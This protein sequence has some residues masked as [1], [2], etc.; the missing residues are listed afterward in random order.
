M[1]LV[2][3][4]GFEA[5]AGPTHEPVLGF[6]VLPQNPSA[7]TLVAGPNGYLWGTAD[8][9][10]AYG[11][12]A[13]YKAKMDG[14]DWQTVASFSNNGATNKGRLPAA[15]LVSDGAG[16]FWGT[17][18]Q[19]GSNNLGTVFKVNA[20][21]GAITTYVEFTGTA[22]PNKGSKPYGG[23]VSDG[24]G[25]FWGTTREGGSGNLLGMG[26]IFK[27]DANTG[28]L[29][30]VVEFTDSGTTKGMNPQA[31]LFSDGAGN[32]WGTTFYGGAS[33][34]GTVFKINT[35]SG[36][37]STVV[38]FANNSTTKGG[39]PAAPLMSDGAGS[40][41]GTTTVGGATNNGT[42]FKVNQTSSALTTVIEFTNNGATNKGKAPTAGLVRDTTG[43]LWGTTSA[44]GTGGY[45]TVF[46][47]D[48]SSN[49]LT[50]V[51]LFNY[52]AG[53]NKG[54]YPSAGLFSDGA[55]SIFGTTPSGAAQLLGSVFRINAGTSA[56]TTLVEFNYGAVS[57]R[58][59]APYGALVAD[60]AGTLWSTTSTGGANGAGTIF[61][62]DPVSGAQAVVVDFTGNTGG[63]LGSSP[64]PGLVSDGA[65]SFW[66]TTQYGGTAGY[67]TIFKVNATTGLLTTVVSFTNLGGGF[68]GA[69]PAA[70]L[71]GDGAGNFWGTTTNGGAG[72]YGTVFKVN[73]ISGLFTTVQEFTSN[74]A[75]NKGANPYA[76]LTNDSAGSFWGVTYSGGTPNLG[77][78]YKVNIASGLLT[79]V[80]EFNGTAA[81]NDGANPWGALVNDGAG[82]MWGTTQMGGT[83]GFGTLF[84]VNIT[85]SLLTTI[86]EFTGNGGAYPGAS[87]SAALVSD[88]AGAYWGTTLYGGATNVGTVFKLVTATS[89]LT[90]VAQFTGTGAQ[91]FSGA[92][93]GYGPL[94]KAAD[95]NFYGTTQNGGPGGGGTVFRLRFGPTPLTQA[96]TSVT[97]T[98]ATLNGTVN[99]NG[100]G[101]TT[102]SFDYGI[103][104]T[105]TGAVQTTTTTILNGTAASPASIPVSGLA[106][107]TTYYYRVRATNAGNATAQLGAA[108][109]FT[110][111]V[112]NPPTGGSFSVTPGTGVQQGDT[113]HLSAPGWTD[114]QTPLSYQFFRDAASL[115]AAGSATTL[116]VVAPA[117][118]TYLFR[119]RVADALGSYTEATQSVSVIASITSWRQLHF[120]T[121]ANSGIAA[122]DADPNGNGIGNLLEYTLNGNPTATTGATSILPTFSVNAGHR[123]QYTFTRYLDRT[124]LTLSVAAAD[125]LSGPWSDLA[126]STAAAPF[127]AVAPGAVAA[128]T[129]SG[130][131]RQVTVTD[132]VLVTDPG[133]S[134]RFLRLNVT[135]SV[136]PSVAS[137]R[138]EHFGSKASSRIAAN[139][140]D[141]NGNGIGNLLEYAL[142]GDPM[143]AAGATGILPTSTIGI[144]GKL[145]YSFTR[146]LDRTDLA[147]SVAVANSPNGPWTDLA[148][149]TA[150]ATFVVIAPGAAVAE[151]GVG[152]ARQVTI[153]DSV[154]VTDPD[155][156]HRFLR[157]KVTQ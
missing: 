72:G 46:K 6:A 8:Q 118:G 27:I 92:N 89:A 22:A 3:I 83:T 156:P 37:L 74:G 44:G 114:P 13:I 120:G 54:A 122:D 141:P 140:A 61:K 67:G 102:A 29:T 66:G 125:S 98:T 149:S 119:V 57:N 101:D 50:T 17:T 73:A 33:F 11:F 88:G 77:T 108:S 63:N 144:D 132:S 121:T 100:D 115:G 128:E 15:G 86:F 43:M 65:G 45:G 87:P 151:S 21:T 138:V 82:S 84:K 127:V 81:P 103:T 32:L 41:W 18:Q 40:F 112:N 68:K 111:L 78:I 10:G 133:H 71:V 123:I 26:T 91:A 7:G 35:T 95:G 75:T 145:Q 130:N 28:V 93:P 154:L 69:Y 157:L 134:H 39:Q 110:T 62:V 42:V 105:F 19:G 153:T 135:H 5:V 109:S 56:F 60:A 146:Y 131:T 47:I 76:A 117:P 139:D 31:G 94:Y 106:P 96:A 9:G 30:T 152:G 85:S 2:V 99:P 34:W 20:A 97:F 49:L 58:G 142:S 38:E 51:T 24:A 155:Y 1:F 148:T 64:Y 36:V 55:G 79:T 12:G 150:A 48:P 23:L 137:W 124:D 14:T 136:T 4:A 52:S 113:L 59:R 107:G 147:L 90:S 116:D 16:S 53:P 143:A 104:P 25:S 129:G 70:G 126:T 80:L